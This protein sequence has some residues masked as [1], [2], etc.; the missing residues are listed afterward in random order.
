MSILLNTGWLT[1]RLTR[2]DTLLRLLLLL[3]L[4]QTWQRSRDVH[5]WLSGLLLKAGRL[6]LRLTSGNALRL[7]SGYRRGY[8]SLLNTAGFAKRLT[9]WDALR[10]RGLRWSHSLGRSLSDGDRELKQASLIALRLTSL[11]TGLSLSILPLRHNVDRQLLNARELAVGKTVGNA[12]RGGGERWGLGL[13]LLRL[14][15]LL[16]LLNTRRLTLRLASGSA[17]WLRSSRKGKRSR[18]L[19]LRL[20]L[21]LRLRLSLLLDTRRL[22]LRLTRRDTLGLWDG[23]RNCLG[24]L[25]VGTRLKT[26]RLTSWDTLRGGDGLGLG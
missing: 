6:T 22:T 26:L 13:L 10:L 20:D 19:L 9:G 15:R 14:L 3:R 21:L 12:L 8:C 16:L 11:R 18:S 5:L 24:F 1:L 2:C 23:G 17:A 7:R 4:L 25:W